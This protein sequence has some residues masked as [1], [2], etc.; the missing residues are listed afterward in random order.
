MY[1]RVLL[2][3]YSLFVVHNQQSNDSLRVL[4]VF[5]IKTS[6]YSIFIRCCM[7]KRT[8]INIKRTIY[9]PRKNYVIDNKI[10]W[11]VGRSSQIDEVVFKNNKITRNPSSLDLYSD[12]LWCLVSSVKVLITDTVIF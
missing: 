7:G 8:Y 3:H 1:S 5:I 10:I 9:K 6:N 4:Y 11:G 12:T 2:L